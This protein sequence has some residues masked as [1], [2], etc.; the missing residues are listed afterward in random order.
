MRRGWD[1]WNVVCFGGWW[2]YSVA[3]SEE[4]RLGLVCLGLQAFIADRAALEV[5]PVCDGDVVVQRLGVHEGKNRWVP[6]RSPLLS[7]SLKCK[8]AK[9]G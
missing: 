9:C 5:A 7:R 4:E 2:L 8:V 1:E 6:C 3:L